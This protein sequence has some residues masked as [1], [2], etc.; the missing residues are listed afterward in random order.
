MG[1]WRRGVLHTSP[2]EGAR[3]ILRATCTPGNMPYTARPVQIVRMD[4]KV[5]G[6]V[7]ATLSVADASV[8][9]TLLGGG[10]S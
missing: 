10:L 5:R 4:G 2:E 6:A 7:S 3:K 8:A 1:K 9:C